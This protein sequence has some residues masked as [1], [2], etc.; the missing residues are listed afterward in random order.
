MIVKLFALVPYAYALN[1]KGYALYSL[2]KYKEAI[3]YIDMSLKIDP[4]NAYAWRNKA[5]IMFNSKRYDDALVNYEKALEMDRNFA[6]TRH[7]K[8][9]R[10]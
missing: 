3:K 10:T 8:D 1:N 6:D 2:E 5:L 4:S 9:C 7:G